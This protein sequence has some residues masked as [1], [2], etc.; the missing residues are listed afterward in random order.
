M[1]RWARDIHARAARP[2]P[3]GAW[4]DTYAGEDFHTVVRGVL[5]TIDR[6]AAGVDAG[7][8]DA[9]HAAYTTSARLEWMFWDSAYRLGRWPV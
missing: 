4:I 6:V 2:N 5:A 1:P 9:M 3:Y 7:T 8:L